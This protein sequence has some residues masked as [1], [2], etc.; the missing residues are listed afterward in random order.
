LF[1][2]P[3]VHQS[4]AQREARPGAK[5][6]GIAHSNCRPIPG[7]WF[8]ST[9]VTVGSFTVFSDGRIR[10]SKDE[11]C[12]KLET[13]L[14]DARHTRARYHSHLHA[15]APFLK[16]DS[17]SV[18]EA[19]NTQLMCTRLGFSTQFSA[20]YAY[21]MLGKAER[22]W[23]TLRDCASSMLHAMSV[24][25]SM[26]SCSISTVVHLRKRTY[27][28]AV[29]P[30]RGVLVTLLTGAVPDASVF[31]V[32]GC[33]AFAKVPDT[34][35]RK[36][37]MKAFR[38][39]MVGYSHNSPGYRIYT[40][41][42]RRI[43]TSVHVK[44][45]ETVPGFGTCHHVASSIDVCADAE[46]IRVSPASHPLTDLIMDVEDTVAVAEVDRPTRLRGPPAHFEDYVAH[47]STVPRV[48]VTD[49]CDT[50]LSDHMDE[51]FPLPDF[52]MMVAHPRHKC[53]EGPVGDIALVSAS[54]CVEPTSYKDAFVSPQSA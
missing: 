54:V 12:A 19:A 39:V 50:E 18:F 37:G 7:M 14:L 6:V 42:T 24:P 10:L 52:S 22:P 35:R 23:R 17:D 26:W 30:S 53:S 29:G 1:N 27:S 46:T 3:Y 38:G 16:F 21:H 33:A 32:F 4:L 40:P 48:C 2:G 47:M 9:L 36:L 8:S 31:R 45:E 20:P 25:N 28:R 34:L 49:S 43:T 51:I 11:T 44:F 41:A 5:T 15:F 13:I